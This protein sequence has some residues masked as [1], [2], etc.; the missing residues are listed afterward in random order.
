[1]PFRTCTP[2]VSQAS[3]SWTFKLASCIGNQTCHKETP[4][5]SS[6]SFRE[7]SDVDVVVLLDAVTQKTLHAT[8]RSSS[9]CRTASLPAASSA[10][11]T[12]S[13]RGRGMSCS[14]STTTPCRFAGS[15]PL[16]LPSRETTQYKRHASARRASTMRHATRSFSTVMRP[17]MSLGRSSRVSSYY[18]PATLEGFC[19]LHSPDAIASDIALLTHPFRARPQTPGSR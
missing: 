4:N 16:S 14:S 7:D 12:C 11:L 9:R 18:E 10:P 5:N 8:A 1:M 17:L 19:Q 3:T 6:A 13:R 15:F 2:N